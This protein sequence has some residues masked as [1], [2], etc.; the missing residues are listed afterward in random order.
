MIT[1]LESI[2]AR[3]LH[4][5][6]KQCPPATALMVI[7]L[8]QRPNGDSAVVVM[9]NIATTDDKLELV[10]RAHETI[11]EPDDSGAIE[12]ATID[13]DFIRPLGVHWKDN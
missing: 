11:A 12:R 6:A 9:S 1:P 3:H 2:V 4:S 13:A 8:E 10:R 7:A 5:L